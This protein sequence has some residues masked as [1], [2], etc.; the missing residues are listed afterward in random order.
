MSQRPA[1]PSIRRRAVN[2][3]DSTAT[4]SAIYSL[5]L[6]RKSLRHRHEF[7]EQ[8]LANITAELTA[9]EEEIQRLQQQHQDLAE[10]QAV[11]NRMDDGMGF[12]LEY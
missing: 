6:K 11:S 9:V 3:N 12:S 1:N 7:L 5:E 8:S 4:A 10:Q 2:R